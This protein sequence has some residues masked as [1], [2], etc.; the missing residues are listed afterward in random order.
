M[1]DEGVLVNGTVEG[2]AADDS[3]LAE[4]DVIVELD[5]GR[6]EIVLARRQLR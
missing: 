3:D 2:G 4:G 1:V 5:H 6:H